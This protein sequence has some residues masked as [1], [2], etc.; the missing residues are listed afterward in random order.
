MALGLVV[1]DH[2]GEFINSFRLS[3]NLPRELGHIK[4]ILGRSS[5][6]KQGFCK[7]L[8]RVYKTFGILTNVWDCLIG[9]M[10]PVIPH[11]LL[12]SGADMTHSSV[13]ALLGLS[14]K[15]GKS[16]PV[17]TSPATKIAAISDIPRGTFSEDITIADLTEEENHVCENVSKRPVLLNQSKLIL[18]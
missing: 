18:V 2:S 8:K 15:N 14:N 11:N 3:D 5:S 17:K 4:P 12:R 1:C 10:H 13:K 6:H 7:L 16:G 9:K